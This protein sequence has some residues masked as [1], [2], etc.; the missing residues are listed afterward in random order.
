MI[1]IL[2]EPSSK[3]NHKWFCIV[4]DFSKRNIF[5]R[6]VLPYSGHFAVTRSLIEGLKKIGEP[7]VYNP[8]KESEITEHVH[9]LAGVNTLRYA[10]SLKRK[11]KI[12]R[13]T[14]GPNIVI[15]SADYNGLVASEEIDFYVVNSAW[16]RDAY[17]ADNS[18]LKGR[19]AFSPSGVNADFWSIQKT[20]SPQLRL[21]FYK[22][23]SDGFLYNKCISIAKQHDAKTNEIIYG[24]YSLQ[25]LKAMLSETD[26]VI[27]FGGSESQGIAL[28]EI[29]ATDTP[30]IVFNKEVW[31]Y[32][33]KSYPSSSAPYLNCATGLFFKDADDF[34]KLFEKDQL[35]IDNFHPRKWVLSDMTDEVCTERFLKIIKGNETNR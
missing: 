2:T 28:A 32:Q 13:L 31:D 23:N 21:L 12:K 3:W 8:K 35:R 16:T 7:F 22:K 9:V 25:E 17:L 6:S 33:N 14:A 15:S 29:W 18:K 4:K 5:K 19:I 34:K 26:F 20:K 11:G 27:Y 1:T 24:S 10:I 30:T